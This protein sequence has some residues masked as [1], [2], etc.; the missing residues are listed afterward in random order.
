MSAPVPSNIPAPAPNPAPAAPKRSRNSRTKK[1]SGS[2]NVVSIVGGGF[3]GIMIGIL[4]ALF[5]K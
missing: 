5:G 3:R 4:S 1:T 2:S